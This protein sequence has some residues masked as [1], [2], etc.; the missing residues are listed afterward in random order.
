MRPIDLHFQIS[1]LAFIFI[2]SLWDT[3]DGY[4]SNIVGILLLYI[5]T[6]CPRHTALS[7]F[8]CSWRAGQVFSEK[9]KWRG[10]C[11]W[12]A[13]PW[14]AAVE[15]TTTIALRQHLSFVFVL[16]VVVYMIL[17]WMFC[18]V[19]ENWCSVYSVVHLYNLEIFQS[20]KRLVLV[21]PVHCL[22]FN[23]NKL[24]FNKTNLNYS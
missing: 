21:F 24:N 13:L 22:Y 17:H 1:W 6:K 18:F 20:K 11:S 5:Q 10:F 23:K 2:Y 8:N 19:F 12:F 16:S 14:T 9:E 15:S 3:R 4:A 7:L